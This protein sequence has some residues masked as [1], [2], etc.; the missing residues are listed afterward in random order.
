MRPSWHGDRIVYILSKNKII[1]FLIYANEFSDII[2]LFWRLALKRHR[3]PNHL[4]Q[5]N[6]QRGLKRDLNGATT[7][8]IIDVFVNLV[9]SYF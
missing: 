2:L 7:E 3:N 1:S 6:L 5:S 9:M 8:I 4:L